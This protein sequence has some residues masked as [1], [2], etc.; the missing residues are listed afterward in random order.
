MSRSQLLHDPVYRAASDVASA[1]DASAVAALRVLVITNTYPTASTPGDTPCIQD[2]VEGLG[3]HG[4]QTDLLVIDRRSRWNYLKAAL[5][6]FLLS[7]QARRYDL[8]HAYYGYCG[9]L[10]R[11]Q[12]RCP[13][14]ITFRGSDLLS[15]REGWVGRL[16]ARLADGVI[17]MTEEMKQAS[18]RRDAHVI[19]FGINTA[20]FFPVPKADA[21]RALGLAQ[22]EKLIL[23]PWNPARPEKRFDLLE[24]ALRLVRRTHPG[25]RLVSVCDQPHTVIAQYMNACDVLALASDHEGSPVA[26]REALAC[27]LP[28]V[29]V[30]VGDVAAL[31]ARVDGCYLARQ[32]AVDLAEKLARALDRQ[33]RTDS[34]RLMSAMDADWAA[35]QVLS[36]YEQV[37]HKRKS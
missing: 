6:V 19:P 28:V 29:S 25:A 23:F 22:D 7:F 11:L 8:I 26:V 37:L 35:R 36:V 10:A 20:V 4:V 17:V 21:R 2:Q 9:L 13:V 12:C 15:R 5:R 24:D 31:I 27:N 14:V 1:A 34:V 32:E 3:R 30:D 18:G 33:A 16:A